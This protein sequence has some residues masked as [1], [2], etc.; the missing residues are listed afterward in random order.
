MSS[1]TASIKTA[2]ENLRILIDDV[3]EG[4]EVVLRAEE[5]GS[6]VGACGEGSSSAP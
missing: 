1:K 3:L 4:E 5:T 6:A 2:R